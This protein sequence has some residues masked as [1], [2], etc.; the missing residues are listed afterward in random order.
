MVSQRIMGQTYKVIVIGMGKRGLHHA[1]FFKANPR[2]EL[3]GISSRDPARLQNASNQAPTER[4][5]PPNNQTVTN[6][7]PL[8]RRYP[9][10]GAGT[11][12]PISPE[13]VR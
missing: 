4:L 11:R 7:L 8:L 2:F 1:T 10:L 13:A 5:A 6:R 9:S 3:V 12:N